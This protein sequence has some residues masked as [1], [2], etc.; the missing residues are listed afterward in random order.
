MATEVERSVLERLAR[1]P[2]TLAG[3]RGALPAE[4]LDR[5]ALPS[6]GEPDPFG[7]VVAEL[8]NRGAVH[9]RDGV[10]SLPR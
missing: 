6:M 4:D 10:Y 3:L 2:A 9:D 7:A 1:G 8:V 5:R